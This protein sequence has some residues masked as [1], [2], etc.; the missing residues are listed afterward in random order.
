MDKIDPKNDCFVL[1][2]ECNNSI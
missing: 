1:F 2:W